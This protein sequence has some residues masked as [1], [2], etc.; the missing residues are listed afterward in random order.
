[1][2]TK[3]IGKYFFFGLLLATLIFT[4]LIFLP[5][6]VVIVL[7]ISF[8]IVLYPVYEWLTKKKIPATLASLITVILF[9]IL[10]CGPVLGVGALVFNQSQDVYQKVLNSNLSTV[11]F[12]DKVN[13]KINDVLPT[14]VTFNMNQKATDFISYVYNHI[15]NIFSTAIS[16][17][18]SFIL[19]LLIIFYLLKDGTKWKESIMQISPLGEKNNE[20]II[21]RLIL[22]VNGVING[23]LFMA[24]V[25]GLILGIGLWIFGIP[26]SALW[27]VLA[28]VFSFIPM[29][30][31]VVISAPAIIFLF[32]KGDTASA[33]GLTVWAFVVV[34]LVDN[35]LRP[36]VVGKKI[37]VPPVLILLSVLGGISFLGPVGILVGPLTLS[38]LYALISI[39]KDE[40]G[41]APVIVK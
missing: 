39:Y 9:A 32:I 31:A 2:Q 18:F 11:P 13:T 25:Q 21:S 27:G 1:M 28:A 36:I 6:W 37:D 38:L 7:G 40:F 34:G 33:L 26:N 17:F 5:F 35:F 12:L 14:G 29:L 3:P 10:L 19:M 20:K 8:S 23:S 4:F 24:V 22:S 16:A 30:G 15:A 41:E